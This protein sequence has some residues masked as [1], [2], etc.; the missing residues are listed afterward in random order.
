MDAHGRVD[1]QTDVAYDGKSSRSTS[2]RG[3][4]PATTET[5]AIVEDA[6]A[7]D[8][9]DEVERRVNDA[10]FVLPEALVQWRAPATRKGLVPEQQRGSGRRA[11]HRRVRGVHDAAGAG[12]LA[13]ERRPGGTRAYQVDVDARSPRR[14][15]GG[16]AV[17]GRRSGASTCALRERAM[18]GNPVSGSRTGQ[19]GPPSERG[20]AVF[21]ERCLA[22][23]MRSAVSRV[24]RPSP[25]P[26]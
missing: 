4:R 19:D 7:D 16:G 23:R 11:W 3:A 1:H 24:R 18:Y 15:S 21:V 2:S 9:L 17:S 26:R 14:R 6:T 25:S 20:R 8:V 22:C 12:V 13:R 5:I 10:D